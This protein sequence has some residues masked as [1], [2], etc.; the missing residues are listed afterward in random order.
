MT[1]SDELHEREEKGRGRGRGYKDSATE[2]RK[3]QSHSS[4]LKKCTERNPTANVVHNWKKLTSLLFF[5]KDRASAAAWP[6][7]KCMGVI[8][9]TEIKLKYINCAKCGETE[10]ASFAPG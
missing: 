8:N 2:F 3:L 7:V 6:I 5:Q 1:E 9:S 4:N 10:W